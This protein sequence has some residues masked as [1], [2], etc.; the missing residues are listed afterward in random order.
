MSLLATVVL[1]VVYAL[2]HGHSSNCEALDGE[3]DCDCEGDREY[4]DEERRAGVH[5]HDIAPST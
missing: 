5:L 2:L 3:C 1:L 4:T